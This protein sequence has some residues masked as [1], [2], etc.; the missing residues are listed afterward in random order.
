M[1]HR[2]AYNAPRHGV[3][4]DADAYRRFSTFGQTV[5]GSI[6]KWMPPFLVFRKAV[7]GAPPLPI[8]RSAHLSFEVEPWFIGYV[9]TRDAWWAVPQLCSTQSVLAKIVCPS[10]ADMLFTAEVQKAGT[11]SHVCMG[12][13]PIVRKLLRRVW[14]PGVRSDFIVSSTRTLSRVHT[15]SLTQSSSSFEAIEAFHCF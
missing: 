10:S 7:V 1:G 12:D 3:C 11:L 15:A 2:S 5:C 14:R 9:G 8:S 13:T 6:R 4:C